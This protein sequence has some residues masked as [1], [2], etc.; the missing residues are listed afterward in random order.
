VSSLRSRAAYGA[1]VPLGVLFAAAA[2]WLPGTALFLLAIAV[3]IVA[4]WAGTGTREATGPYW[5]MHPGATIV[6]ALLPGIVLCA[7]LSPSYFIAQFGTPKFVRTSEVVLVVAM[8]LAFV[9]GTVVAT[10]LVGSRK[11]P[12]PDA[13]TSDVLAA[14][15]RKAATVLFWMTVAGYVIW[16]LVGISRG[17]RPPDV[18]QVLT[19]GGTKATK[20]FLAPVAG[21][22]T[23]TQFGPLAVVAIMLAHRMEASPTSRRRLGV[24]IVL[25]L[26]RAVIYA[27][28]IALIEI[29][30]PMAIVAFAYPLVA[31]PRRA[32]LVLLPLWV[33]IA[34][35]VFF[36]SFEYLRSYSSQ[37]YR[38]AYAGRSY[39]DFTTT[40]LGAY[41]ATAINNG[42][43]LTSVDRRTHD[44]PYYT[45][46][47]FWDFPVVSRLLPYREVSGDEV[48]STF[49][50]TLKARG[51][52]EFNN[53]SAMM[54]TVFDLGKGVSVVFWFGLG[55][56]L[57]WC[58]AQFRR[59]D[60]RGLVI[61]PVL[62]LGLLEAGLV[63]YWAQGRAVPTWIGAIVLAA[64]LTRSSQA[65]PAA[66]PAAVR[67]RPGA[68]A[69]PYET[70][71]IGGTGD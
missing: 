30:L 40:R 34:L 6:L 17:L 47:G 59:R 28:R 33:P 35:L 43:L 9:A 45:I 25:A 2:V 62:F 16:L 44:V 70:R 23:F 3:G 36:G 24:L 14:R 65:R 67:R 56:A 53:P 12:E 8:T 52:P 49:S 26:I 11:A 39:A 18:V 48:R 63:L 37:S 57:G 61:Y 66:A 1:F 19:G 69:G 10:S 58:Y 5:W 15:L 7:L 20:Q 21:A 4:V 55:T 68:P 32:R 41:F 64:W 71:P 46:R 42:A 27:E 31:G 54:T 51:N 38:N 29:L 22:T 13:A 50:T 60:I